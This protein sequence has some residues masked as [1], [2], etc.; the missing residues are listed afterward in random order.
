MLL[1]RFPHSFFAV[2]NLASRSS[3]GCN[4]IW[5]QDWRF[6]F[7][8]VVLWFSYSLP[9]SFW[10]EIKNCLQAKCMSI[11]RCPKVRWNLKKKEKRDLMIFF[12]SK[13]ACNW[14]NVEPI[15]PQLYPF[16]QPYFLYFLG[17]LHFQ[18]GPSGCMKG[19]LAPLDYLYICF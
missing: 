12:L 11:Q 3:R 15:L 9:H 8:L 4:R 10:K 19:H 16:I 7:F 18:C 17:P 13:S 6:V 1:P 14:I 5:I 2:S